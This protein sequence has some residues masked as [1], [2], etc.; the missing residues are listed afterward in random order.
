M[1]SIL[2]KIELKFSNKFV[3]I[4]LVLDNDKLQ[5][6]Y[7]L[8]KKIRN[9][10]HIEDSSE[11][12]TDFN[13]F[14]E[15][16]LHKL[17]ILVS[18]N[19]RS[20]IHKK[21]FA[22]MLEASEIKILSQ[23]IPG[24]DAS[25]LYFQILTSGTDKEL[26]ISVIR[27]E[28]LDNVIETLKESGLYIIEILLGPYSVISL[29]DLIKDPQIVSTNYKLTLGNTLKI[30]QEPSDNVSFHKI[31]E[32]NISGNLISAFGMSARH[33][34]H[35]PIVTGNIDELIKNRRD[36]FTYF[37]LFKRFA[38]IA[39]TFIFS[40]LLINF[41]VFS[42]YS[43]KIS[44]AGPVLRQNKKSVERISVLSSEINKKETYLSGNNLLYNT[45]ISYY[46]DCIASL[47]PKEMTLSE[48]LIFPPKND[49][50]DK[51]EVLYEQN[52]IIIKGKTS[53]SQLDVFV[54]GL[55]KENWVEDSDITD[56]KSIT[57]TENISFTIELLIKRK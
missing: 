23:V 29:G 55:S 56:Y 49:I 13:H 7:V 15:K 3:G 18:I 31:G 46:A 14:K 4:D 40:L 24:F 39:L 34:T 12:L 43:S 41:M 54:S 51:T 5:F 8:I 35:E 44:E 22:D 20:I 57:G 9:T 42:N 33:F 50:K 17:P 2:K 30:E 16:N 32:D 48:L 21:H 6:S 26:F 45:R 1:L 19:G 36:E 53:P 38:L 27:K 10:L 11:N 47:V 25:K 37:F 52:K 28:L